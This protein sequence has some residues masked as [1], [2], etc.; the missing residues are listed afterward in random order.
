MDFLLLIIILI[1]Q[2]GCEIQDDIVH[3]PVYFQ[4]R[5]HHKYSNNYWVE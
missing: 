1:L 5:Y 2:T 4:T 3:L